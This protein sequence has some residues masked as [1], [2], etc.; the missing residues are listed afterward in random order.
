MSGHKPNEDIQIVFTGL[1]PG[2]KLYEELLIDE[3]NLKETANN[4]IFVAQQTEVDAMELRGKV[5][6]LIREARNESADVRQLVKEIVP[7]Y[8]IQGEEE[9]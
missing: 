1:R 6:N 3:A 2:E 9:N 7:E 4:R 5:K 8:K